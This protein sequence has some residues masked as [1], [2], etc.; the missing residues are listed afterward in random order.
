ML[1]FK[2]LGGILT[3]GVVCT[4][5]WGMWYTIPGTQGVAVKFWDVVAGVD[6]KVRRGMGAL[7]VGLCWYKGKGSV[8]VVGEGGVGGLGGI[9]ALSAC[10]ILRTNARIGWVSEHHACMC[11]CG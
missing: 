8:V 2:I 1:T 3:L 10:T 9:S 11:A 5:A 6:G 7:R 4:S